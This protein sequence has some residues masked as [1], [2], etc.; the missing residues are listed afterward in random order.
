MKVAVFTMI[1]ASASAFAE[2]RWL[3]GDHHIHSHFNPG[4][5]YTVNPWNDL[6]FYT[7]PVFVTAR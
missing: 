3:A 4:Y 7:N 1:L 6:W 2:K 5:D